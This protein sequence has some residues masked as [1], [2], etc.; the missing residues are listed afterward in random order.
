MP[1]LE[2]LTTRQSTPSR[3]L[4]APAPDAAQLQALLEAAIRVPDHGQLVPFRLLL[5]RDASRIAFGQRIAEIHQHSDPGAPEKA[6]QK[7]RDR[8]NQ[9]PLVIV[10]IA[11]LTAG[12][13]VPEQE[14]LLSAGC[15][16]YNILLGA[17]ALGFGAQ[18]L[19][20]WAAYDA[21]VAALLS[22]AANEKVIGFVHVGTA[23]E[24]IPDRTR[25]VLES[26]CG[27][28]HPESAAHGN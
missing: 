25:P 5:L 2:T 13:K 1:T 11:R 17:H 23:A 18:W 24:V 20:G 3:L 4:N 8:F 27:E 7:D 19:T 10:V 22:L 28:W 15:V 12:H 6:L 16:A 21:D 14:Q 26:V 9:A